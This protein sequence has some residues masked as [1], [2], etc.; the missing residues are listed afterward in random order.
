M[1]L[2]HLTVVIAFSTLQVLGFGQ[3]KYE[4]T[5][6]DGFKPFQLDNGEFK[7]A[8]YDKSKQLVTVYNLDHSQWKTVMLPMPE[9]HYLDEIKSISEKTFNSDT[10]IELVYSC[11]EHHS[12]NNLES[13]SDYVDIR[14]TLYIIN[15][16]GEM[17]LKV[18]DSNDMRI[19]ESNGN[20]KLLIYKHIGQGSNRTGEMDVYSL[21]NN[22]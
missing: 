2:T 17:I 6:D 22:Q 5:H 18:D 16:A 13:T 7:Y 12:N 4:G 8:R 11:V 20:R 14:F 1:K 19:I 9:E 15:E 3:I 10:L 21:P